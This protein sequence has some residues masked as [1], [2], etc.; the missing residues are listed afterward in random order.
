MFDKISFEN[1]N[2]DVLTSLYGAKTQEMTARIFAAVDKFA[3]IYGDG[4]DIS[5][6]SVSG[7]SEICGNHTDHNRGEVFAASIDLDI[8]AVARKNGTGVIS[9]KSEG[10]PKDVVDI[11]DLSVHDADKGTSAALIRGVCDGFV[12]SG[13]EICGF[14]C[15]TVSSVLSGSG[16]SSSA[17][18]EDAVGTILNHFANGGNIDYIKIS[19]ISQYA[20]NAHFGKP[21]GLMDQ[22]ACAAGGFVN[23]DFADPKNP[24]CKKIPF[25]I[26]KYGYALCIVATGGSHADLTDDYAAVPAEM[27]SVASYFGKE[28]LREISKNDVLSNIAPLRKVCGDRAILRALHFFDENE[29]VEK[30]R[31]AL[32][33]SDIDAFLSIINESGR[34]SALLLQNYFSPKAPAEQG[35]TLACEIIR[36]ILGGKGAVRVHGGGFAGTVQAFVPKY[37]LEEFTEKAEST[38]GKGSVTALTVRPIGAVKIG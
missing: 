32:E 22:V 21:C 15:Y 5:V 28:V 7:R 3:Q 12:R 36:N 29:R 6:F 17:A 1:S 31:A 24:I 26:D 8:I 9:L 2:K 10:F 25:D 14:D 27:K 4:G 34:S 38:F 11:S 23:I 35:V 33:N 13:L 37:M 18:F 20:E 16:L 30:M 19:Q